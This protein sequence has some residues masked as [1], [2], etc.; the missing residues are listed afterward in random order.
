MPSVT[1]YIRKENYLKLVDEA[2][3][4]GMSENELINK[5]LEVYFSAREEKKIQTST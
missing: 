4:L 5:I 1:I 3:K 2:R